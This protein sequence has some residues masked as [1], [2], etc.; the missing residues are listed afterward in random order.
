MYMNFILGAAAPEVLQ[1]NPTRLVIAAIIGLI[2][3]L[4]LIIKFKVQAMIAI[5]VGA[6]SIGI[7]AGMP[8]EELVNS[9]NQGIGET[10]KG[11]ALLVG[12]GSM[13]GA[14][15]EISGGAQVLA[16]TMVNRF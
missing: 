5:L 11:I 14:I 12:L 13:F 2:I 9:V 8:L 10:L 1:L 6:I 3:L 15:L 16:L 7:I 4:A